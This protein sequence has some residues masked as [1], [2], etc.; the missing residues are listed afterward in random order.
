MKKSIVLAVLI[1][2]L[3]S[4]SSSVVPF[5]PETKESK[6]ACPEEILHL[7]G[8]CYSVPKTHDET[9]AWYEEK[10]KKDGWT[11]NITTDDE[12]FSFI[13]TTKDKKA[14]ITFY[15]QLDEKNTGLLLKTE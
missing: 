10:A 6:S 5:P 8:T 13:L 3:V 4:C 15:R 7:G 1:F 9:I 12:P 14:T 11:F 2:I